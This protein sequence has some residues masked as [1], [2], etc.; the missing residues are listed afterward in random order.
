MGIAIGVGREPLRSRSGRF[1]RSPG[2]AANS[3]VIHPKTAP[4]IALYERT[5]PCPGKACAPQRRNHV[6]SDVQGS[7][8]GLMLLLTEYAAN[9]G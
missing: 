8:A 2:V 7:L 9:R 3:A 1:R 5:R 4:V 6:V